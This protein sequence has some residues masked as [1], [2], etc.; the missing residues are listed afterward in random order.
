MGRFAKDSNGAGSLHLRIGFRIHHQR[1]SLRLHQLER[2][3]KVRTYALRIA[4]KC[5]GAPLA[6]ALF[7]VR[8]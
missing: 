1:V 3:S 2:E 8:V 4:A 7:I 6:S 5:D